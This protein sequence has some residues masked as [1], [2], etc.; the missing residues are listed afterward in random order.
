MSKGQIILAAIVQIGFIIL[1]ALYFLKQ[2]A[3][4]EGVKDQALL[5][6]GCWIVNFTTIVNYFFGSSKGSSDKTDILKS[7]LN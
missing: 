4:P 2:G 7:K 5:I 1:T 3:I 6:T